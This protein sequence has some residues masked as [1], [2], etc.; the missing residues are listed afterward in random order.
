MG[1]V[2]QVLLP[3]GERFLGS[4]FPGQS[5][6]LGTNFPV[7]ALAFD[8][9]TAERAYWKFQALSYGSGNI[10]ATIEWYADTASSGA[11]MWETAVA[12]ITPNTD[13][14]DVETKAFATVNTQADTH[15][16][17]TGQRLHS[18]DLTISNLDSI[19]AG[20]G[21]WLRVSRLP[22]DAGDTMTGDALLTAV[23]LAYSDT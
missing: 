20:D 7:T 23:T 15:L 3:G 22:A 9:T 11:V 1:T 10:T 19:A 5:Q 6:V 8:A 16:G 4:A 2:K 12:A 18:V 13:S 17:T 21:V 14:G